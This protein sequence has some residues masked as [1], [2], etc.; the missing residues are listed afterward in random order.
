VADPI[1][2]HTRKR[3]WTKAGDRCAFTGC[4]RPLLHP[5]ESGTEDTV[6]GVECHIVSQKDS[7]TVARSVSSLTDEERIRWARLIENRHGLPNLVLMCS[8]HSK[9]IDDSNQGYSVEVVVEMKRAQEAE[10]EKRHRMPLGEIEAALSPAPAVVLL[11]DVPEWQRQATK[12]LVETDPKALAWLEGEIGKPAVETRVMDLIG[13]WPEKL[14]E[15]RDELLNLLVREAEALGLWL[16]ATTVWERLA[17]RVEGAARADRLARAAIDAGVGGDLKRREQLLEAAEALDP[18]GIRAR[19]ERFDD[20]A[21]PAEQLDFLAGI[22]SEDEKLASLIAA[23]ESLA[24]L[25]LADLRGAEEALERAH[26]LDP[27][28]IAVRIARVN[29]EVQ[30]GRLALLE[31]KPF[32]SA[33]LLDARDRALELRETL[34]EMGRWEESV[35]LLMMA[36][37]VAGLMRDRDAAASLLELARPEEIAAPDG[38]SVL[39]DAA[40]RAGSPALALR[41]VEGH[42]GEED[43]RRIEASARAEMPGAARVEAIATLEEMALGEG[44]EAETAAISRLLLCLLPAGAPWNE[45]VAAILEGGEYGRHVEKLRVLSLVEENP[46]KAVEMARELPAEPWAAE[47]RLRVAGAA[48]DREAM[49]AAA[50]EFL[51]FAPD[52]SGRLLSAQGLARA[53]ELERAGEVTG[54]IAEDPNAPP[55][56]RNDAFHVLMKTLADREMWQEANQTWER[57]LQLSFADLRPSDKRISAWQVRVAHNR[58]R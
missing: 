31:D 26:A 42:E 8:D 51:S 55:R 47:V 46:A 22:E 40:M 34:L 11:E 35:R 36:A 4:E 52:A 5:T 41:F 38:A 39:G 17:D 49:A 19:L 53:G 27:D 37:D 44:A 58:P 24:M 28:S 10:V 13:R 57:W 43:L 25:M 30:R 14:S 54:A 6:V 56:V 45:E 20:S 1:G 18:K 16:V 23:Q 48:D 33:Q 50:A 21:D 7:P 32:L 29:L 15:G 3:L 2:D 12:A 9:V